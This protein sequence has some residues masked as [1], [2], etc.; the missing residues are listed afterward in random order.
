MRA[1]QVRRMT[2]PVRP[3]GRT[4]RS[5]A[6]P[7]K[8]PEGLARLS[9]FTLRTAASFSLACRLCP[10]FFLVLLN[11]GKSGKT[12]IEVS[13]GRKEESWQKSKGRAGGVCDAKADAL[14]IP[15]TLQDQNQ[16]GWLANC[17]LARAANHISRTEAP[18]T[19]ARQSCFPVWLAHL[20]CISKLNSIIHKSTVNTPGSHAKQQK[21]FTGQIALYKSAVY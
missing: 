12:C 7:D 21:K 9:I 16:D 18:L 13:G 11:K 4:V 8:A 17:K 14:W 5:G 6:L 19:W 1:S 20:N 15:V 3:A 10:F 2:V